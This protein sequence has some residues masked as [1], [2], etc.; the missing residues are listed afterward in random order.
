MGHISDAGVFSENENDFLVLAQY[1]DKNTGSHSTVTRILRV[2]KAG[3]L[4]NVQN[5]ETHG[6][7][8]VSLN[9]VDGVWMLAIAN[10]KNSADESSCNADSAIYQWSSEQTQFLLMRTIMTDGAFDVEFITT[11]T[12]NEFYKQNFVAFAQQGDS[13]SGEVMIFRYEQ[14]EGNFKMSQT[15]RSKWPVTGL[16]TSYVCRQSFL[17]T[18]V[19]QEGI[20]FYEN[21][22]VEGFQEYY[23][24]PVFGATDISGFQMDDQH[25]YAIA[26]YKGPVLAEAVMAGSC[27]N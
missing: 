12:S 23:K 16:R 13:A 7:R 26:T 17:V 27:P 11:E 22:F 8:K 5:I 18:V 10:S 25:L 3:K 4:E 19:P 1:F 14:P 6:A 2:D 20:T 21:R 24:A 15:I 9:M